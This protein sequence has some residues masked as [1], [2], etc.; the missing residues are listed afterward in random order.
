MER[1]LDKIEKEVLVGNGKYFKKSVDIF[2]SIQDR[3]TLCRNYSFNLEG[4][5]RN[6]EY[7]LSFKSIFGNVFLAL[8]KGKLFGEKKICYTKTLIK[9][10]YI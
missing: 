5:Y 1:R 2:I 4:T 6:I 9:N 10:K 7:S 8:L 3:K